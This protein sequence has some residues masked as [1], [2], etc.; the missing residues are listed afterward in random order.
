M[1]EEGVGNIGGRKKVIAIAIVLVLA[2]TSAGTYLLYKN[3]AADGTPA[4]LIIVYF[5]SISTENE[6]IITIVDISHN[7]RDD[8]LL[9]QN[10]DESKLNYSVECGPNFDGWPEDR[11]YLSEI[12]IFPSP[13]GVRWINQN[14]S[15]IEVGDY[16]VI[17]KSGGV[18]G[19]IK[20]HD[21]FRFNPTGRNSV[22]MMGVY[23][24]L[25]PAEFLDMDVVKTAT[26]WN[27]TVTWVNETVLAGFMSGGNVSFR[28]ESDDGTFYGVHKYGWSV[29]IGAARSD[30]VSPDTTYDAHIMTYYNINWFDCDMNRQ[31]SVNDTIMIDNFSGNE[32][33]LRFRMFCNKY[34][35]GHE[36]LEVI[37]P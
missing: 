1:N 3:E 37:F 8:D 19:Q 15:M 33:T 12:I 7:L 24:Y 4:S 35:W 6:W 14:S 21:V 32:D 13:Y 30:Y 2:V 28:V 5:D 29:A 26:G 18:R 34:G 27:M 23:L 17:N 31:L 11:N 16:F 20:A 36:I 22:T 9:A 10:L 25:P